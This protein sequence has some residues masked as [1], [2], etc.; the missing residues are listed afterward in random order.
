MLYLYMQYH[1]IYRVMVMLPCF[2][3][4]ITGEIAFFTRSG[5]THTPGY[6]TLRWMGDQVSNTGL[7]IVHA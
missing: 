2:M 7:R 5:F 4:D 6:T 1:L 3:H